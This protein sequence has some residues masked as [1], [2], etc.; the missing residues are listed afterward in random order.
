[1]V[2]NFL[3]AS[4]DHICRTK[5]TYLAIY[6]DKHTIGKVSGQQARASKNGQ[7]KN[8]QTKNPFLQ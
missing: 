3:I 4:K 7:F 6:H 5:L 2:Q 8:M 1:M